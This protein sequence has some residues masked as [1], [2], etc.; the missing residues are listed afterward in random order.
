MPAESF[1]SHITQGHRYDHWGG[2][3][4]T[5]G[6][7]VS[8]DLLDPV[9][10]Y[11]ESNQHTYAAVQVPDCRVMLEHLCAQKNGEAHHTSHKG[12][13]PWERS[14][15]RLIAVPSEVS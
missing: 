13:K 10:K 15:E 14:R 4:N 11:G 8:K 6:H 12:V 9:G 7:Q 2:K 5:P 3:C 1:A